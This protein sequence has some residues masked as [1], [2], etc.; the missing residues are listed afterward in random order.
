VAESSEADLHYENLLPIE[1]VN[2]A[3]ADSKLHEYAVSDA[4]R[5]FFVDNAVTV[6][7][8]PVFYV[9]PTQGYYDGNALI[10]L[11]FADGSSHVLNLLCRCHGY[12]QRCAATVDQDIRAVWTQLYRVS[13]SGEP[14]ADSV[15]NG[16]QPLSDAADGV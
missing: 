1:A 6:L 7:S 5:Q 12:A 14:D 16:L 4:E 9:S 11:L 10:G 13:T 15:R 8:A 3:V 2:H